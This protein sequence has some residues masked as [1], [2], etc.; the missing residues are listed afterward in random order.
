MR[1]NMDI[2][3]VID[4]YACASYIVDYI[5]K[6]NRGLSKL[7][8]TCQE[9][10]VAGNLSI[11]NRLKKLGNAFLNGSEVSAQEAAWTLLRLTMTHSSRNVIYLNT[12]PSNERTRIIRRREQLERLDSDSNDI[13]E[14]GIIDK[15][16]KRPLEMNNICLADFAAEYTFTSSNRRQTVANDENENDDI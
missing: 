13:F 10:I 2:Q 16:Q 9:E 14:S 15:Y 8:R 11:R 5:N 1:S 3:F 12:S 4:A 6:S 7:L